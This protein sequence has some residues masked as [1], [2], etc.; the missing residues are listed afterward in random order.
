MLQRSTIGHVSHIRTRDHR[1]GI[2]LVCVVV[3]MMFSAPSPA[4][5][6]QEDEDKVDK[7]LGEKLIR[8]VTTQADEDVMASIMRLMSEA[9]RR[10]EMDFNPG[11]QTQD[12]Q[13][14]VIAKLDEAIA[15]AKARRR[16]QS[17]DQ[18]PSTSDRR[19]QPPSSRKNDKPEQADGKNTQDG[20]ASATSTPPG[21]GAIE[22]GTTGGQLEESRRSWGHLPQRQRDEV[23]QGTEEKYLQRY[24]A[25]I[26]RYYRALQEA[27]P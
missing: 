13:Q 2:F 25:W 26:Q 15:Q 12:I 21:G 18:R 19:T 8:N 27:Q 3:G 7:K 11:K 14:Q 23:I 17:P 24:R 1:R 6:Q 9:V 10:L 5:M 20:K 16:K 22:A 4:V